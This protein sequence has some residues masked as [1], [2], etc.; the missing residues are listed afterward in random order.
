MEQ[1]FYGREVLKQEIP[2]EY[3]KDIKFRD[4]R[5]RTGFEE[6]K[7]GRRCRRCNA[8]VSIMVPSYCMCEEKCGYCTNC[9]Q[10]GKIKKCSILY[11]LPEP[12]QFE[13]PKEACL[14]WEGTL[15]TQ[16]AEA[17][18][19]IVQSVEKKETRLLW[20]VAGAGKT[21]ML[22]QG[23]ERA[24]EQKKRICIASPRVDVCLELA[25]RIHSAF[26]SISL[27][28]LYGEMEEEYNYTQIVIATTHQMYR[29]KGAFDV[30]VIDEID[31]FPFYLD[32]SLQ[33]AAEKARKKE[34]TLIYLTATPDQAIQKRIKKGKLHVS[35]LPARYHGF[36]L[37]V[38]RVKWSKDWHINMLKKPEKTNVVKQ[39]KKLLNEKKRFLVFVPNINWMLKFEKRL[40][41]LFQKEQFECVYSNDPDRKKKVQL[42]RDNELDFLVTTT[43][44]ER[45]VT[46][47]NIDVL[48]LGAEDRTFTESA[49]VQIAG[50]AGRS[51][52]FPTGNVT[53]YHNGWSKDMKRAIRQIKK[54]NHL[55]EERGLLK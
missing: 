16:Q 6:K 46:F 4:M 1:L 34:S 26:P 9:I 20:A 10:M 49:L 17:S 7:S 23:I 22:F 39:I 5:Q 24:I 43:I 45:G 55:A 36:P 2:E 18:L 54:M 29:F 33:F 32:N 13:A 41:D 3:R 31:A 48:V 53:F 44:L 11:S 12:N 8:K 25:P 40:I 42:M 37:P 38:P 14:K 35:I 51:A 30:L 27:A 28:V 47:P 50:R 52:E 19:E 15:S 21:E